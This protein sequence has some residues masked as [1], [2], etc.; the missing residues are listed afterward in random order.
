MGSNPTLS[1][2]PI[3]NL[4]HNSGTTFRAAIATYNYYVLA[5]S[6]PDASPPNPS[7]RGT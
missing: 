2:S 7:R 4:W 1:V 5:I 6:V 3:L